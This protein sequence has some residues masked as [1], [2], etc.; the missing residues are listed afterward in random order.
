VAIVTGAG[1]GIG[2]ATAVA[3]AREGAD[4]VVL[5]IAKN[6]TGHS[7]PMATPQ[8]L[9]ETV[10]LIESHGGRSL[11]IQADVRDIRAMREAVARTVG[12]FGKVDIMF[13]NAG[14]NVNK[15][16]ASIS[17]QQWANVMEVNVTG[18]ANSIRAVLPHMIER[19]A[20]RVVATSSTFGRQGNGGNPAYVASKWA[21]VG[22]VK[23]AAL[24]AGQHNVTVNAIAPTAVRTGLGGPQTDEQRA[25][26]N[27]YLRESYHALPVGILEPEDIADG[28]LFLV[29]PKARHVTGIT[30]DVAAGANARYTA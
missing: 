1:R 14:I 9:A 22:L 6:I 24:E 4:V 5:D 30:L 20:G 23:A 7:V 25:A 11:A 13:A 15:P 27:K 17:D 26:G 12:E 10:K 19:K 18:V 8:E 3:L 16:L 28:V 2:R 29:S 21:V